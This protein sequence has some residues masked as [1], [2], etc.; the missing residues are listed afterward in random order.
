[1]SPIA[2]PASTRQVRFPTREKL[3]EKAKARLAVPRVQMVLL[4]AAAGG[5]GF[6]ASYGL[7][8]LGVD[9]MALRYPLAVG[10]AYLVFFLLLRLWL[11]FQR[12][13]DD[14][15]PVDGLDLV[16]EAA[17]V[18]LDSLSLT[19][20][21]PAPMPVASGSDGPS[22]DFGVPDL[23]EGIFLIV[24]A[25]VAAIV[26]GAVVYVVYLAP[27]LLAEVLV[28]GLLL[29]GFY[30]KLKGPEPE[31]WALCAV[32]RTWIPAIIVAVTFFFAGVVFENLAPDARSIGG[33]WKA[34]SADSS[35][36]GSP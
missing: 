30:K 35:P 20:R 16:A 8:Q 34:V 6:L 10:A 23:D 3:V 1:M 31:H 2:Q 29:V 25:A 12:E 17:D 19:G 4:L 33:V 14:Y 32:R 26:L 11:A 18:G 24:L 13:P 36:A 28:D 22:L 5:A 21:P 27:L 15:S 9:R 7:L